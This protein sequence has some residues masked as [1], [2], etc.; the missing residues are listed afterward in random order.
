MN[1]NK[2][3]IG[4]FIKELRNQRKLKI[5][6][7]AEI[8]GVSQPYLSQ[9]E[10]GKRKPSLEIVRKLASALETDFYELAWIAGY[11]TLRE[12]E[13]VRQQK[14]F[15]ASMTPEEFDAYQLED[16]RSFNRYE[17]IRKFQ[18]NRYVRLEDFLHDDRRSF[19][20]DDHK[21]SK[22]DIK[23]LI[24]LYGGKE[25]NYPSDKQI[26]NEYE[27]IKNSNEEI[28]KLVKKDKN[29]IITNDNY[30]IDTNEEIK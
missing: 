18:E 16:L 3:D 29:I 21:L 28:K 6:K 26:E 12:I 17:N 13:D 5:S 23:M 19:Y 10:S 20:I 8:S 15:F 27:E 11:Y 9:I 24:A 2:K 4:I 14:E 1:E 30:D 7:L 25:K 22:D